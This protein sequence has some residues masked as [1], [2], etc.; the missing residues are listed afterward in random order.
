MIFLELVSILSRKKRKISSKLNALTA[1]KNGYYFKKCI[2]NTKKMSKTS[3]GL[4]KLY[5]S[6]ESIRSSG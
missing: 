4:N 1:K 5:T 3:F 2:Q 6:D